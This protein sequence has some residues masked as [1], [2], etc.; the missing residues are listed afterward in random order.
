M[1]RD[2]IRQLLGG[3]ATGTLTPEEQQMLFAAALE[4]QE[5]FDSLMREQALKDALD[6]PSVRRELIAELGPKPSGWKRFS[7]WIRWPYPVAGVGALAAAAL[8]VVLL[9]RQAPHPAQIAA[10]QAPPAAAEAAVP[11]LSKASAPVPNRDQPQRLSSPPIQEKK[12]ARAVMDSAQPPTQPERATAVAEA[13]RE[14]WSA[15][16]LAAFP[17][18]LAHRLRRLRSSRPKRA[19]PPW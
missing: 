6:D 16:S 13:L 11:A 8:T 17:R 3:Y 7:T 10:V 19:R 18:W 12:E 5:L 2:D 9:V 1:K 4:D 14:E 15:E